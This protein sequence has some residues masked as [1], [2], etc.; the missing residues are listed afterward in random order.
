[1]KTDTLSTSSVGIRSSIPGQPFLTDLQEGSFFNPGVSYGNIQYGKEQSYGMKRSEDR[2]DHMITAETL[3]QRAS[4]SAKSNNNSYHYSGP[5]HPNTYTFNHAPKDP[6][7]QAFDDASRYHIATNSGISLSNQAYINT[8]GTRYHQCTGVNG[9]INYPGSQ[10]KGF[11]NVFQL[12]DAS[13]VISEQIADMDPS[14]IETWNLQA[15]SL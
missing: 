1:M 11:D 4:V 13:Y 12:M 9:D 6:T 15:T 8:N 5:N 2:G 14:S 3:N 7:S 10:S